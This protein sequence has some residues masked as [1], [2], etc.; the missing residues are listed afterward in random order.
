[1]KIKYLA[2]PTN[3]FPCFGF[4]VCSDNGKLYLPEYD[5]SDTV[6]HF[7][8]I[9]FETMHLQKYTGEYEINIGD[10][11]TYTYI[12]NN[13]NVIVGKVEDI[14]SQLTQTLLKIQNAPFSK[15]ELAEFLN[16]DKSILRVIYNECYNF[17][18]EIDE[19]QAQRWKFEKK[20]SSIPICEYVKIENANKCIEINNFALKVA[21]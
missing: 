1:M 2:F 16:I 6:C 4:A 7:E 12:P 3:K 15:L 17:L 20:Y 11:R 18:K 21:A 14:R 13:S 5:E 19:K 9:V 10:D 8:E